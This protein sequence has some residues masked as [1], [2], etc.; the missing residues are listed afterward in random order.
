MC[1]YGNNKYLN[2]FILLFKHDI[3]PEKNE[4][5]KGVENFIFFFLYLMIRNFKVNECLWF[6]IINNLRE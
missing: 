6:R 1:I 3:L 2:N 5:N 4:Y